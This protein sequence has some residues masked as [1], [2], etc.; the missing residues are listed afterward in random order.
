MHLTRE[1]IDDLRHKSP[2][3]IYQSIR[4]L[5]RD[6]FGTV[7]RDELKEALEDAIKADLLDERDLRKI[8]DEF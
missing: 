8:E 6:E 5:I 7:D 2:E 4:Q 3:G 1:Q